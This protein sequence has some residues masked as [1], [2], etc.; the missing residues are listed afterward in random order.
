MIQEIYNY[1]SILN[2][3]ERMIEQSPFKK[4]YIIS[5]IGIS[6]PTFYRKLKSLSFT[7]DE[8]LRIVRLINAEEANLFDLKQ[9]IK[10]GKSDFKSGKI[11]SRKDVEDELNKIL[12]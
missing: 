6:A 8:T 4:G 11:Y 1:K 5:E 2:S 9:S 3:L 12:T 7:P 10:R